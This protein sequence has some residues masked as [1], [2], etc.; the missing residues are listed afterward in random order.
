MPSGGMPFRPFQSTVVGLVHT[1]QWPAVPPAS[2]RLRLPLSPHFSPFSNLVLA[3]RSALIEGKPKPYHRLRVPTALGNGVLFATGSK[4][5]N[6]KFKKSENQKCRHCLIFRCRYLTGIRLRKPTS[7]D[8]D[9]LLRFRQTR[10][11]EARYKLGKADFPIQG[12]LYLFS[13]SPKFPNLRAP[14]VG[15][16]P[17]H[18]GPTNHRD[19]WVLFRPNR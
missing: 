14:R 16:A 9:F 5:Q 3:Q 15:K 7:R 8:L 12:E 6:Q 11:F 2:Q 1:L 19:H 13:D 17:K 10:V 4:I 18:W